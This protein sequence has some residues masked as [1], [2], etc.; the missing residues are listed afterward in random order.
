M[1]PRCTRRTTFST[2]GETCARPIGAGLARCG[3]SAYISTQIALA[4]IAAR[5]ST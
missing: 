2:I 3:R 4:I 1:R 5:S